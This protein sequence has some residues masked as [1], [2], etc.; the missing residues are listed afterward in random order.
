[1][2]ASYSVTAENPD[3]DSE[4]RIH[5]DDVARAYGFRGGLVPGAMV[6]RYACPSV[7]VALGEEWPAH[8]TAAVRFL[9]PVYEGQRIR[10][11]SELAASG[12]ASVSVENEA[13]EVCANIQAELPQVALAAPD[14]DGYAARPAPAGGDRPPATQ[15]TVRPGADLGAVSATLDAGSA[16]PAEL[17]RLAN[18]LLVANFRVSPWIHAGSR[19]R[20]LAQLAAGDRV[21]V[22]GRVAAEFERKGHR[23]LELDV[24]VLA[25]GRP[26]ALVEHTAIYQLAQAR[27]QA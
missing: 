8:G 27:A 12:A 26:C 6:Y 14:P 9:R 11:L 15:A 17:L 10:I 2:G 25:G 5:S 19:V 23:F 3:A 13:G 22:R 16:H 21:E 20:H 4:N 24:L 18:R 7:V 1:M